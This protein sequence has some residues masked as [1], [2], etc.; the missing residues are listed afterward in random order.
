MVGVGVGDAVR[1][2]REDEAS[3]AAAALCAAPD[4]RLVVAFVQVECVPVQDA[5]LFAARLKYPRH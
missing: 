4:L 2:A 1:A 5:E 3:S